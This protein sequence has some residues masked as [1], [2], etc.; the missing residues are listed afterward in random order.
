MKRGAGEF[1]GKQLK[2]MDNANIVI[3]QKEYAET[4]E[5]IPISKERR[6]E[7]EKE[8]TPQEK[9]QMRGVLGE[10]QWLVT[11]SRPDLA[12]GCSLLQQRVAQPTVGD[13]IEVNRLISMARD[14][15]NTE[16]YVKSIHPDK[17]EFS[18]WSDASFA[19][20]SQMKSQGGYTVCGTEERLRNGEWADLSP[21]RWRSY[22]QD[23]QV[24]STLGAE[25]M[26]LSRTISEAKWVRSLW[27]EAK[28]FQYKLEEDQLWS[29]RIPLTISVDSRPVF[30]HLNGQMMTIKDKR[31]AIECWSREM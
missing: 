26:T 20:A 9:T 27:A 25:L 8:T 16:I 6:K 30:D 5:C 4:I 14:F 13:M 1:L 11:G 23:R 3:Q 17:L 19:N 2:Q 10:V 29:S 24:A 7:K 12:A 21:L 28:F 31:M 18:A 15:S 22:K